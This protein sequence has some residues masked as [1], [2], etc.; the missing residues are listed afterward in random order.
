MIIGEPIQASARRIR[1]SRTNPPRIREESWQDRAWEVYDRLGEV[2][3]MTRYRSGI[4]RKLDYFVAVQERV[5]DDPEPLDSGPAVE[6]FEAEGGPQMLRRIVTDLM[7]HWDVPGEGYLVRYEE[8]PFWRIHSTQELRRL[9]DRMLLHDEDGQPVESFD[10]GQVFRVWKPHPRWSRQADS[11]TKHVLEVAEELI[12][13]GREVRARALSRLSAG[14][15]MI[16]EGLDLEAYESDDGSGLDGFANELVRKMSRPVT[17]PGDPQS[18]VPWVIEMSRED[19]EAAAKGLVSF[20]R[21]YETSV[22]HRKELLVRLANGL[23]LPPEILLGMTDLNHWCVDDQTEILTS[24]GWKRHDQLR[25]GD[26]VLTLDHESGMSEWQPVRDIYRAWVTDESMVSLESRNH[27]SLTTAGHRWPVCNVWNGRRWWKTSATLSAQD[28]IITAALC[29]DIPQEPKLSDDL[30]ELVA[31]FWTE[32]S[33]AKGYASIS[34]SHTRNPDRVVRIRSALENLFGSARST[35]RSTS[36]PVW[37]EKIQENRSSFGG[38][39]TVFYLNQHI[40]KLLSEHAPD[41]RPTFAFIRSLTRSQL[42]LFIRISAEGDGHHSRRDLAIWQRNREDLAAYELALILSG[43]MCQLAPSHD[44]GWRLGVWN[45]SWVGPVKAAQQ[46]RGSASQRLVGYTGI[47]WCPTT[48]NGSWLARRNGKICYTGNSAWLVTESAVS[49]HAAPSIDDILSS[50]SENWFRPMLEAAG[51]DPENIVLWRDLSPATVPT[52]RS[53]LTL[54][55]HDRFLVS[56]E[57]ARAQLDFDESDAPSPAEIAERVQR[58]QARRSPGVSVGPPSPDRP[59]AALTAGEAQTVVASELAEID[60]S[61]LLW[62]VLAAERELER[63]SEVVGKRLRSE[64]QRNGLRDLVANVEPSNIIRM[65]GPSRITLL[66]QGQRLVGPEDFDGFATKLRERIGRAWEAVSEFLRRL[67]GEEVA[68]PDPELGVETIVASLVAA[69]EASLFHPDAAPDPADLGEM[70]DTTVPVSDIRNGLSEAG[71]GLPVFAGL[72]GSELLGNG[73]RVSEVLTQRG[74]RTL[75]YRWQ[76][77]DPSSRKV[78]FQPHM[79]LDGR[80]FSSWDDEILKVFG[81]IPRSDFYY[82]GDHR[83][84][85]CTHVRE[86]TLVLIPTPVG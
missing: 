65:L 61:L 2:F 10:E 5:T 8:P 57:A 72:D 70:G 42:E 28:R 41:K 19:I 18:L 73:R 66:A 12:L 48:D 29:A 9:K 43:R 15:W 26:D 11:P 46:Q 78:N 74:W 51:V 31:W 81:T 77:G 64:A 44:D 7:P 6:V 54:E 40:R 1:F 79:D 67:T 55:A 60:R 71:G 83:G 76:Y 85:L 23:D 49:Q 84:C 68:P 45:Q 50:L 35:L 21:D 33:L 82:P 37:R 39:V 34:Q 63:I 24:H 3:Y 58:E 4:A 47:V 52:D 62:T 32:G 30:V 86:L 69:V 53:D 20:A 36:E 17:D 14:V 27:S 56:D 75:S 25:V 13:L 80:T 16:P 38:P 59:T 22:D